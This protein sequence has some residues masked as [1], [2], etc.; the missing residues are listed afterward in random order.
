MGVAV[1]TR[2][3]G[4]RVELYS[5]QAPIDFVWVWPYEPAEVPQRAEDAPLP[6][7]EP[8]A[9]SVE[10]DAAATPVEEQE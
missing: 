10:E 9:E 7:A 1:P 5:D 4:W 6:D 2:D 8:L 3:G